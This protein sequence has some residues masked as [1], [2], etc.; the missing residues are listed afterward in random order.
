MAALVRRSKF[1]WPYG[2]WG[3]AWLPVWSKPGVV[4]TI[5]R[6]GGIQFEYQSNGRTI[7]QTAKIPFQ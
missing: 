3:F 4:V 2:P 7:R 6:Q 1:R 5:N